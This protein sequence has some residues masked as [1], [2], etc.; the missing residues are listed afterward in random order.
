MESRPAKDDTI[1][2]AEKYAA[3][4]KPLLW[5]FADLLEYAEGDI[6]PVFNKHL[7]GTHAPWSLID[8]YPKRVRLPQREYLLCSRVTKMQATTGVYGPCS[9]TTEYDLPYDGELP[10]SAPRAPVSARRRCTRSDRLRIRAP[11]V[12]RPASFCETAPARQT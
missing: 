7:S 2:D 8:T 9:M 3:T 4:G 10:T 6:A 1:C 11:G 12:R 5:D